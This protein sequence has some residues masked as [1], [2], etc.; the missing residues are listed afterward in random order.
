MDEYTIK[1]KALTPIWTGDADRKCETLRETG[2][3]GSLRWWY[4]ALIRGLG[5]YA[6]D[7]TID[8][9]C[10][11]DQK[12]FKE[13]LKNGKSQQKALSEQ[14][15]P[16]CQL[17]GCTGWARKFVLHILDKDGKVKVGRAEKN[18]ELI[19]EFI[20]LKGISTEEWSLLNLTLH[21]IAEYGAIGGKTVFKPSDENGREGEHHHSDFGLIEIIESKLS[22]LPKKD[23][24]NYV[25]SSLQYHMNRESPKWV[26]IKNF[27]C[28]KGKYLARQDGNNSTFNK[29]LGRKEPKNQANQLSNSNDDISKWLA[30]SQKES[31]KIFSFKT[32]P[33]TFG[34]INPDIQ[35]DFDT[36]KARL[37]EAW[38]GEN[39][40]KF[41]TGEEAL[42]LLYQKY[43]R[44]QSGT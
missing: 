20:P 8:G 41:L 26:S 39:G 1:I 38:G 42:N 32:S 25:K 9:R 6:C 15:C 37:K 17:F 29:V 27:W 22:I 28:V 31:K 5:G 43:W 12:R 16:A 35:I 30:G 11:L 23:L 36:I 40:W 13:A 19:F 7:P 2:I 44:G 21:F 24:E 34:F 4:E 14:I 3:I 33:R 10:S 18:E